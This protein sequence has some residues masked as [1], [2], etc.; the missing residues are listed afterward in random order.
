MTL[1]QG[2]LPS[3]HF[4]F[5]LFQKSPPSQ[6]ESSL[7]SGSDRNKE[8]RKSKYRVLTIKPNEM[9]SIERE[10]SAF[11]KKRKMR[12][13]SRSRSRSTN[14]SKVSNISVY[15]ECF[16]PG[17]LS[18]LAENKVTTRASTKEN[19]RNG[20]IYGQLML[21]KITKNVQVC[22]RGNKYTDDELEGWKD[23]NK[24]F[25]KG[26]GINSNSSGKNQRRAHHVA[27]TS[28]LQ[29]SHYPADVE[30]G[31]DNEKNGDDNSRMKCWLDYSSCRKQVD[32]H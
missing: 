31:F 9:C 13:S 29:S 14:R 1:K 3:C 12:K 28:L 32:N 8:K 22:N 6:E 5:R 27:G 2:C 20:L 21:A 11:L 7:S 16:I 18:R 4:T 26:K 25:F 15:R 17:L 24:F 10:Y 23:E 30:I 19:E